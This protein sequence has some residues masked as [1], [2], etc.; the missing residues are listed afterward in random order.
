METKLGKLALERQQR[1][2]LVE[3][4]QSKIERHMHYLKIMSSDLEKRVG[5]WG[6]HDS[7]VILIFLGHQS[8]LMERAFDQYAA[9]V[10][11]DA[12]QELEALMEKQQI[13]LKSTG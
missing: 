10:K 13:A 7:N 5:G 8:E 11:L 6:L 4:F 3:Q 1:K 2:L 12:A 9:A